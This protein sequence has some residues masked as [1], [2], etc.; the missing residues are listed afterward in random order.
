MMQNFDVKCNLRKF[1][2][3]KYN[4][5]VFKHAARFS[6]QAYKTQSTE[7]HDFKSKCNFVSEIRFATFDE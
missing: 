3:A 7:I 5:V 1:L 6:S 4:L 2:E